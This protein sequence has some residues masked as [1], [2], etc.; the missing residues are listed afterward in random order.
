MTG[1]QQSPAL[2]V[3]GLTKDYPGVRAVDD[4]SFAIENSTVHCL[5]GENGA[6][7]ST[8]VKMLTGALQPTTGSMT[9]RGSSYEP[10]NTQD[11]RA[12]GIATLFQELH[13]VDELTVLENLTLGMEQSRF[14]FLVKSDLDDRVVQTLA[15]IEPSIDP[16]ARVASLSVA[17]KQIIEIARAASSGAN[18]IIMDEP[19]AALSEREV[20][21]LFGVIRRLRETDV[22]VIYIS[23]KLDEIFKLGDAV[24]VLRDGKHIATKPLSEVAGRS[25]LIEM[26]IGR[27]VFQDY[28]PRTTV[29]DDAVLIAKGLTNTLL[30]DVS[31]HINQGE[32]VGFYGLVGAGKT[33]IA[34]ALFGADRVSGSILF[35]GQEV[36]RSPKEAIAAG[37]A[38]V[39]EE[40]RTQGLFTSLTIRENIPVM[41][42]QRLSNRGVFRS[43]VEL[44][45]AV[46][47]VGKLN[48]ATNSI[49]KYAEKLSG[50]NQQKVVLAKCLFADADLLLL[51]EPTRGVDVGAKAEIY[52]II[53]SVADEGNSVAVFSSEL[54]EVLGICDRIFLL[55]D[56]SLEAEVINGPDVDAA[57]ILNVVTG[58]R[59][60]FLQ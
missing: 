51:D 14:G 6:G 8:L 23:H 34:R 40:R 35:K 25:E 36:G 45:A 26:M 48:I 3:E 28:T 13:V 53:R 52:D 33:E 55:F 43:S 38:L 60:G 50:G 1:Q 22:T 19:T 56:G 12:G 2:S 57:H 9:V 5:V 21:R 30:K 7:K 31:F 32:I 15:A 49:D 11:A 44:E 18:V 39:P 24:T 58:G 29:T 54:E 20:E 10:S 16:S 42:L 59:E 17:Q 41:N 27:S 37:I 46:E 4:V 47:Y